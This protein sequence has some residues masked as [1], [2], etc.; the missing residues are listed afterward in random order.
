LVLPK[1]GS[2]TIGSARLFSKPSGTSLV[3]FHA[4]Y[5]KN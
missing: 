5:L 4:H 2:A 1:Y 3:L